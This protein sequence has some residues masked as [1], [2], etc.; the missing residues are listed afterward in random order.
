MESNTCHDFDKFIEILEKSK[1]KREEFLF[2]CKPYIEGL[3][4][5]LGEVDRL[6][7]VRDRKILDLGCGTGLT[8]FLLGRMG[9]LCKRNRYFR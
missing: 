9:G 3:F 4:D 7:G 6:A 5:I 8:T 1:F 2:H